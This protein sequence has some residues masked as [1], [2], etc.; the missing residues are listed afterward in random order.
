MNRARP[1][2]GNVLFGGRQKVYKIPLAGVATASETSV[3]SA[4][5]MRGRALYE[6]DVSM[7]TWQ[8]VRQEERDRL[9]LNNFRTGSGA[10]LDSPTK[11][12]PYSPSLPGSI[13]RQ[14]STSTSTSAPS[15]GRSSTAATS[16]TSQIGSS[17]SLAGTNF[18]SP[19]IGSSGSASPALD[20]SATKTRRLYDVGLH[21]E[22]EDQQQSAMTRL[23]S[24]QRQ[25]GPGR[26]SPP[27]GRSASRQGLNQAF[28]SASPVQSSPPGTA[29]TSDRKV[30]PDHSIPEDAPPVLDHFHGNP[31]LSAINPNDR[32]KAT[33]MGA[34]NK[35][36]QFSEKAYLERQMTLRMGRETPTPKEHSQPQRHD[37][38]PTAEVERADVHSSYSQST[39]SGR[40]RSATN[41]TATTTTTT[42]SLDPSFANPAQP[43]QPSP[44]ALAAPAALATPSAFSMFQKA[45]NSLKSP[46]LESQSNSRGDGDVGTKSNFFFRD[47]SGSDSDMPFAPAPAVRAPT[48]PLPP[49]MNR[50]PDRTPILQPPA[51]HEHPAFRSRPMQQEPESRPTTAGAA[52]FRGRGG[53]PEDAFGRGFSKP[54]NQQATSG[55]PNLGG[56]NAGLSGLVR[57]HL[58]H[59]SNAS[60]FYEADPPPIPHFPSK[61][62]LRTRDVSPTG[63]KTSAS[64]TPSAT[65]AESNYSHASNPFDLEEFKNSQVDDS[66]RQSPVSPDTEDDQ[67]TPHGA[68]A[69]RR[70]GMSYAPDTNG[71]LPWQQ[72]WKKSHHRD[73]SSETVQEQDALFSEIAKRQRAIQE[74][75]KSK[76]ESESNGYSPTAE[77]RPA[78]PFRGLE[79][80]RPKSSKESVRKAAESFASSKP[81]KMLGLGSSTPQE[82]P[83]FQSDRYRPDDSMYTGA[84]RSRSSSRPA[85]SRSATQKSYGHPSGYDSGRPSYDIGR[86]SEDLPN[87]RDRKN[88]NPPISALNHQNRS[89]SNSAQSNG[90]SRSRNGRYKDDLDKAMAEGTSSRTNTMLYADPPT[91]PEDY[92]PPPMPNPP[93][94]ESSRALESPTSSGLKISTARSPGA[95]TGFFDSKGLYPPQN[96][97]SPNSASSA[98]S[99]PRLPIQGA[100]VLSPAVSPRPSPGFGPNSAAQA[101]SRGSPAAF[102]NIATPPISGSSTPIAASFAPSAPPP[103]SAN[104]MRSTSRKRSIQKSDISEPRL[105]STTSV[106]DTVDLPAGASLRNGLDDLHNAPPVPPINPRRRMFGF[107]RSSEDD[108]DDFPGNTSAPGQ[109]SPAASYL[110]AGEEAGAFKPRHRLR[111]SSS[112]GAKIGMRIRA[113]QQVDGMQ[114]TT[115]L[116][117]NQAGSNS[118]KTRPSYEGGMF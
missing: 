84:A 5:T 110:Y 118:S 35:P 12:N 17:T 107:R 20:R 49:L 24:I 69:R 36:Q 51:Q 2:E 101:G 57:Q 112:E 78:G 33:A 67:P 8:R 111:K 9:V 58:R 85:T 54:D 34:F 91:I 42:R 50:L 27:F 90:R 55:A 46:Q 25:R 87:A 72:E 31:L 47:S 92:S 60:S 23:N 21:K 64:G 13:T 29:H 11:G 18:A 61:L 38:Q 10:D 68:K 22:I 115:S 94:F 77:E 96:L 32:G 53:E 16:I 3:N 73:V 75:L 62:A 79:A 43:V 44:T 41:A 65:P 95:G 83:S 82:R 56:S 7:S 39:Y 15:G 99:S 19:V 45:A 52:S 30:T 40:S 70:R 66:G 105:I 108:K 14:G 86:S 63:L 106:I 113:Q 80:L 76:M 81:A 100:T 98:T 103:S 74:K 4:G 117:S 109:Q 104:R 89:R 26:T 37:P 88:S 71:E 114:S 59:G 1:G 6:D 93:T 48:S 116:A 102:N 28:R 97:H